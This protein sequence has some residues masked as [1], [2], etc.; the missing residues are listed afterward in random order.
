MKQSLKSIIS[1]FAKRT[2][3]KCEIWRTIPGNRVMREMEKEG[4]KLE[5]L[6]FTAADIAALEGAA[7]SGHGAGF[8]L[9]TQIVRD[10]QGR[11]A[12]LCPTP[13]VKSD[14]ETTKQRIAARIF[15]IHHE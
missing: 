4:W 3:Y 15:G 13:E 2:S 6:P 5:T 9:P 11:D 7:R 1:E 8:I 14:F 12:T 10:P